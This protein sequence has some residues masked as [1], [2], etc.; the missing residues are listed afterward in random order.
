MENA[1]SVEAETVQTLRSCP[2]GHALAILPHIIPLIMAGL[3]WGCAAPGLPTAPD[4]PPAPSY[5]E[6]L[7]P[8]DGTDLNRRLLVL[9]NEVRQTHGVAALANDAMLQRVASTHSVD[10]ARRDFFNHHNP[11]GQ[12]PM[13]R[14]L[15][16]SPAFEGRMA[17]NLFALLPPQGREPVDMAEEIMSSWMNSSSHRR[18][19][20]DGS[21][22]RT[23]I[24]IAFKGRE[25]YITQ[26]FAT[27]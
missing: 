16:F 6:I 12:G 14:L 5:A 10:M 8:T 25:I 26:V 20:I 27:K 22:V 19:M 18:P 13:D 4:T 21:Y 1:V 24:G 15:A 23:G 3:L 17:E 7:P 9:I 2:G 11:E